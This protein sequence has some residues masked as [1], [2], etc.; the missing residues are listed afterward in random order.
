LPGQGLQPDGKGRIPDLFLNLISVSIPLA[1]RASRDRQTRTR[2]NVSEN[3]Y[4]FST[5]MSPV[6]GSG[7]RI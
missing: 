6:A 3:C 4:K 5:S 1:A 2:V 7:Y